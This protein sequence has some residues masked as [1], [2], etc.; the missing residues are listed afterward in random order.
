MKSSHELARLLL[1]LPDMPVATHANNH[2]FVSA[3]IGRFRIG[4]L[5]TPFGPHLVIG[6]M[7]QLNINYP[8]LYVSQVYDGGVEIP[9]E[10]KKW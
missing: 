1:T 7:T 2:T 9:N 5:E 6:N 4:K 10:W 8:A 3:E